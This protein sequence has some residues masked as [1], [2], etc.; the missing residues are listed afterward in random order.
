M[1]D[2][3]KAPDRSRT[4]VRLDRWDWELSQQR[5]PSRRLREALLPTPRATGPHFKVLDQ[6]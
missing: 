4:L 3:D 6:T 1:G 5:L 2:T